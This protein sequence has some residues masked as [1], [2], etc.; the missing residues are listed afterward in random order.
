[1]DPRLHTDNAFR[2]KQS[3]MLVVDRDQEGTRLDI[4]LA[5]HVQDLSR[6][7]A[8]Q[9]IKD[10][11]VHVNRAPSKVGYKLKEGDSVLVE[12]PP[13]QPQKG[14]E[15]E[16]V[17]FDVIYEDDSLLVINKPPG[18]VVHP[19][20]GHPRGTL[21]HG[22]LHYCKDL[23]GIGGELR[24]GIVHRLD[25][26]TSGLMAVAKSERAFRGLAKQFKAGA[27]SKEYHALVHGIPRAIC[28]AIDV[29]IGRHRKK[30]KEMAVDLQRGRYAITDWKKLA[31]FLRVFSLLAVRI[32]TGRTHQIRVHLSYVGHPVVGDPVYGYGKNWWKGRRFPPHG[33][34]L[35]PVD[36]QMLHARA[37][38]F[39]HPITKEELTF[40]VEYP[41]DMKSFL[42][43]LEYLEKA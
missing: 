6:S 7:R 38:G 1:M 14:M 28:G 3:I 18:V 10:K 22:L 5:S 33:V 30:R 4:F 17:P 26:D 12:I 9:L 36:R 40:E 19:A 32:K 11:S 15:P 21:V 20:P 42:G 39:T 31:E 29:P 23:A 37:L 41:E 2:A 43:R 35:P 24:P 13:P 16:Q 25:K 8:Q 34:V 27:V